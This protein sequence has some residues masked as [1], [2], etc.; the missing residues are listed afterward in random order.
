MPY[1]L[2]KELAYG[3][4]KAYEELYQARLHGEYTQHIDFQIGEWPAFFVVTPEIQRMMLSIQRTDKKVDAVCRALPGVALTQFSSRCLVDEIVLTNNIEG[5]HSTRKEIGSILSDLE[6][7]DKR[8][9]FYGLV[10]KYVKL[11]EGTDTTSMKTCEEIRQ[12]YDELVLA[13]VVG[14]DPKNRPDGAVF[15]KEA[16]FVQSPTQKNIHQGLYPEEKIISA[17]KKALTYLNDEIVDILYRTAVFH[18]LLGYIHPFYDGNGR[19]NRFISSCMLRKELNPMLAYRLSYTIKESLNDYYKA[20]QICNDP[21]D[22]GDLTPFVEM[23]LRIV[24]R[25]VAQLFSALTERKARWDYYC[26]YISTLPGAGSA[27]VDLYDILIQAALFAERGI[28][29][30]T[31]LA[32]TEVS[33]ATLRKR[34]EPLRVNGFLREQIYGKGK[35]YKMDLDRLDEHIREMEGEN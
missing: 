7:Q 31:L 26:G 25:S 19:L 3:D 9:R 6:G 13:E 28:P 15:R 1:Q 18:Y 8:A 27:T 10:R 5:V 16:V 11:Q 30:G 34:L 14:D 29:T 24:E 35:Y 2:L 4:R 17:M 21:K 20:Y 23:F 32:V 33:R 12:I 22:R